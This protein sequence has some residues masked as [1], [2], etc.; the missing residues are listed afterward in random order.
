MS[1]RNHQ[2]ESAYDSFEA[3]VDDEVSRRVSTPAKP[4]IRVRQIQTESEGSS[5]PMRMLGQAMIRTGIAILAVPDPVPL[6]DEV[7]GVALV[8]GGATIL[9]L[10]Q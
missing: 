10:E 7:V 2:I 8:G 9:Y 5:T 4:E 1:L 3:G 6:I